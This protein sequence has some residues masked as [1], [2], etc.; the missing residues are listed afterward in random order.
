MKKYNKLIFSG[1]I[2]LMV[3]VLSI[4]V[5]GETVFRFSTDNQ[6]ES[7]I[8]QGGYKFAELLNER[9]D[10][11]LQMEVYHSGQLGDDRDV[12]ESIQLGGDM[13]YAG[14]SGVLTAWIPELKVLDLPFIFRSTSHV[15][16]VLNGEIGRRLNKFYEEKGFKLLAYMDGGFRDFSNSKRAVYSI[17]DLKGLKVRLMQ[18]PYYI[19]AMKEFGAEVIVMPYSELFVALKQGIVDGQEN[20]ATLTYT[21]Q[22]HTL[23]QKFWSPIHYAYCSVP[24]VMNLGMYNELTTEQQEIMVQSASD[25]SVYAFEY[26]RKVENDYVEKLREAGVEVPNR[27]ELDLSGFYEASEKVWKKVENEIDIDLAYEIQNYGLNPVVSE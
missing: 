22:M 27:E 23:G 24:L 14:G 1:C 16:A 13:V 8:A 20:N 5:L 10:G 6:A 7:P 17:E 19:E 15:E 11:E 9:T 4:P 2:M 12:A 25:A 3:F 21:D 18:T 26:Y